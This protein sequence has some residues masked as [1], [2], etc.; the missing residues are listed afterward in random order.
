MI[1]S[2]G[3]E[4]TAHTF[5]VGI[6]DE[7]GKIYANEKHVYVPESGGIHPRE[8]AQHHSAYARDV[9]R[10]AL[11]KSGLSMDDISIISF[12]R[13]PGLGPCLR[14]TATVARVLAM[15]YNKPLV[16]VNHSVAHIEIGRLSSGFKDPLT[17]Y[18]SGGNT[19]VSAYVNKRYRVF[20]E[21]LDIPVG[22]LLDVFAREA[23]I[24]NPGG[25]IIEKLAKE[26]TQ[27]IPLP[28][29]VK[30]TDLSFSGLLTAAI[31]KLKEGAYRIEDLAYSLQ[32]TAFAMLVEV[33]ERALA[34]TMKKELLLTGGVAANKRLQEM[35][36][37]IADDHGA[38]FAVVP[39]S[40]AGDNGV[41]IAW[42]G[43]LHYLHGDTLNIEESIVLPRWRL[44]EVNVLWREED[45]NS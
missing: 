18:V 21:T 2:L 8:A 32:E 39:L 19:M 31:K 20:G 16:G 43:I 26:G 37:F 4:G 44:D 17:L 34:H 24:G 41:M 15:K 7:K 22:N 35:L 42:T 27:Y 38:K 3:I 1:I 30:G 5:G 14:T 40:L 6:I 45:A 12:S 10:R 28:Y 33:T 9:L 23:K 29:I 11:E 36:K 25:P 13:G